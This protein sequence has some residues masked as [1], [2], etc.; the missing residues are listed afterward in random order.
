MPT[1]QELATLFSQIADALLAFQTDH[2]AE[3]SV[4]QLATLGNIE[5]SL[6]RQVATLLGEAMEDTLEAIQPQ[7]DSIVQATKNAQQAV[8]TI[9]KVEKV[10]AIGT[11]AA[12]LGAAIVAGNPGGIVSAVAALG[13]AIAGSA[14]AAP[15]AGSQP[16]PQAGGNQ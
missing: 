3:L 10:V 16:A 13:S 5:L 1:A 15:Q 2:E 7:L 12:S 8:K 4:D 9:Q 11:A 14:Q 6:R